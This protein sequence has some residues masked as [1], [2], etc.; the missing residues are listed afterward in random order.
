MMFLKMSQNSQESTCCKVSFLIKLQVKVTASDISRVFSYWRFLVNLISTEKWN[1][2]KE[3]PWWRWNTYFL[4]RISICLTSKTSKEIWWMVIW[5][6]NVFKETLML[7]FSWL[8]ELCQEKVSWW[9]TL[10]ELQSKN[11]LNDQL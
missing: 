2:K 4:A 1:E 5:S 3:V 11:N 8:E 10:D 9:W 6:V 7:Q